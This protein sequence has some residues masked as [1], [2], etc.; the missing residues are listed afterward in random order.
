MKRKRGT[1]DSVLQEPC[2]E[3]LR[4]IRERED[5]GMNLIFKKKLQRKR[6]QEC[7]ELRVKG[8]EWTLFCTRDGKTAS[9]LGI[10]GQYSEDKYLFENKSSLS[11]KEKRRACE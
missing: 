2:C 11:R 10:K 8:F 6:L 3:A 1:G 4:D 5:N 9:K 7:C